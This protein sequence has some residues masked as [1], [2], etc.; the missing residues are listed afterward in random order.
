MNART[1]RK[2][3]GWPW[4]PPTP[5]GLWLRL[6]TLD[7]DAD[8][9][10]RTTAAD[11]RAG[12]ALARGAQPR[13]L[14]PSTGLNTASGITLPWCC[15]A[16]RHPG[17]V[18]RWYRLEVTATEVTEPGTGRD[19]V[20]GFAAV[21]VQSLL[22]IHDYQGWS[23]WAVEVLQRWL[24]EVGELRP[25]RRWRVQVADTD[26][27]AFGPKGYALLSP[28]VEVTFGRDP[29]C[30]RPAVTWWR[31]CPELARLVQRAATVLES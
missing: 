26:R 13:W 7:Y 2:P 31:D 23:W 9:D 1:V 19:P 29:W 16:G 12:Y 25:G 15:A 6:I 17:M 4:L 3:T 5:H 30:V 22:D 14:C 18:P 11:L 21:D 10:A 28:T 20:R 8:P 27:P 24:P